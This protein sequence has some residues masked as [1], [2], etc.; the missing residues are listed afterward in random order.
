MTTRKQFTMEQADLDEIITAIR[1]AANRPLIAIHTGMPES[2]KSVANKMWIALGVKMGF[3]GMT[4]EP[5]H[6]STPRVF[7]AE[8]TS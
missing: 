5:T 6:P 4:V 2:V 7:T 8:P 3:D 1:E